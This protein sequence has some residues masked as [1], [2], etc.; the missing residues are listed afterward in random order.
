MQLFC[1]GRTIQNLSIVDAVEER[2]SRHGYPLPGLSKAA[3]GVDTV[4]CCFV[5]F[6]LTVHLQATLDHRQLRP[7][8]PGQLGTP[9]SCL[10][11]S[12]QVDTCEFVDTIWARETTKGF[13]NRDQPSHGVVMAD[14]ITATELLSL[15]LPVQVG[16]GSCLVPLLPD[17]GNGSRRALVLLILGAGLAPATQY[18]MDA[19]L[20]LP[21]EHPLNKTQYLGPLFL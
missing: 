21:L 20:L 8:K 4:F 11:H 14:P 3:G 6:K 12:V 9:T 17:E 13:T 7:P 15:P 16:L 19:H 10:Y 18:H 2:I 5:S 1:S